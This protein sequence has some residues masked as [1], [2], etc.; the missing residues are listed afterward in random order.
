MLYHGYSK[1]EVDRVT[2]ILDKHGV[3]FK[4]G[5]PEDLGDGKRIPRDSA[6]YQ[7]EI[8]DTEL[9]KVPE[10]DRLKLADLRIY[11][12]MES[13]FTEEELANLENYVPKKSVKTQEHSKLQQ[14]ATILAVGVMLCLYLYKKLHL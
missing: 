6:V 3:V 8:D 12:E 10:A 9:T 2:A 1:V 14:W 7:F 13:P 5:V 4:V 11:G